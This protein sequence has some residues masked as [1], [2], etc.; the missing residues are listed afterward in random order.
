MDIYSLALVFLN[1]LTQPL[2]N[3][4][5]TVCFKISMNSVRANI[6]DAFQEKRLAHGNEVFCREVVNMMSLLKAVQQASDQNLTIF[7]SVHLCSSSLPGST[8]LHGFTQPHGRTGKNKRQL[9]VSGEHILDY[10]SR[11]LCSDNT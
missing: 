11:N 7:Q 8:K 2:W 5:P 1:G 10:R 9:W 4:D 6:L 3:T